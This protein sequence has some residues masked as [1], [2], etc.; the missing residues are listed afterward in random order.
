MLIFATRYRDCEA[1]LSYLTDV[2]GLSEHAVYRDDDGRIVHA[3][4]VLG[5]GMVMFGPPHD[6]AFDRLMADPAAAGGV[7]ATIYAVVDDVEDR[8]ARAVAAGAEIVMPLEAQDYG[9]SS[10]SVRDPEGHVWTFGDYDPW[11]TGK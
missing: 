9:G 8:H 2:F 4:L 5:Q 10:F 3:Q 7:T 6:G 1:A 11:A